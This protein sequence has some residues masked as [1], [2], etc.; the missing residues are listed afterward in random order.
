MPH[1]VAD[2]ARPSPVRTGKAVYH[3]VLATLEAACHIRVH[4]MN[5]IPDLLGVL[6]VR[7]HTRQRLSPLG[8]EVRKLWIIL[9]VQLAVFTFCA[10]DVVNVVFL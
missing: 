8:D 3:D 4:R 2:G 10:D 7:I 9:E 6:K 1:H 5:I